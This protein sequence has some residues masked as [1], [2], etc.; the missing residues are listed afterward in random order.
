MSI[1]VKARKRL[2]FKIDPV[3]L[4]IDPLKKEE[5]MD[6]IQPHPSP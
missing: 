2:L 6:T 1:V 5:M 3:D 4:R